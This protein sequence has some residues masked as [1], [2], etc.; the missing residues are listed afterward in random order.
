M[1]LNEYIYRFNKDI[2]HNWS[3]VLTTESQAYSGLFRVKM[4]PELKRGASTALPKDS[5]FGYIDLL[6][7]LLTLWSQ[8]FVSRVFFNR[9]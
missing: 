8:S 7:F 1:V 4:L 9:L 3:T 6:T 5:S 2:K